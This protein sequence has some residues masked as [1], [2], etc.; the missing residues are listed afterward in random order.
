MLIILKGLHILGYVK[1]DEVFHLPGG[2]SYP[3]KEEANPYI[4]Y[5]P[6]ELR[7]L[8]NSEKDEEKL[9]KIQS[10]LKQWERIYQYPGYPYRISS[11]IRR[12]AVDMMKMAELPYPAQNIP[13][14]QD[15]GQPESYGDVM[16]QLKPTNDN[17]DMK[18]DDYSRQGER[19]E[20][21]QDFNKGNF[22]APSEGI[23]EVGIDPGGSGPDPAGL[24]YPDPPTGGDIDRR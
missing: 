1:S 3:G 9:V 24:D 22:L 19:P 5:P 20:K 23:E 10:A 7:K 16:R 18:K 13:Y 17:Y 21:D 14:Y 2:S 6:N 11:V 15:K 12:I 4:F 8:I